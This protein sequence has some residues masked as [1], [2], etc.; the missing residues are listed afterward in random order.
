MN[1]LKIIEQ[2]LEKEIKKI[3]EENDEWTSEKGYKNVEEYLVNCEV[4]LYIDFS[5]LKAKLSQHKQ[6]KK[7]FE[8]MMNNIELKKGDWCDAWFELKEALK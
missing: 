1:K 2:E 8:E 3:E 7:I 6:D 5:I 4:D